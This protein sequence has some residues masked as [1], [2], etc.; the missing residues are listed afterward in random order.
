MK[1]LLLLATVV[2]FSFVSNAQS[3][4]KISFDIKNYNDT[5]SYLTFYQFDK[6]FIKDTCATIKNGK[7]VFKGKN[8]L[9]KGVYSLVNQNK[10]LMFD[11]I[12]D[13][14][15]QT[16]EINS[17]MGENLLNNL[18]SNSPNEN[19]FFDYIRYISQM[20]IKFMEDREKFP[21]KTKKDTL[22]LIEKQKEV[23]QLIRDYEYKFLQNNKGTYMADVVNIKTEK[24][25]SDPKNKIDDLTKYQYHKNH[26]WDDVNLQDD[27][28]LRNPFFH[29]KLNAYFDNIVEIN[30]D[31]TIVEV[32]K[33]MKKAKEGS[34]LYKL[35]LSH[36][37][38]KYES[39]TYMGFDK[40]FVHISDNYFKKGKAIGIY[41]DE[42][43]VQKIIKRADKLKPLLIGA[44]AP[45]LQMIRAED[46]EKMKSMGFESAS[47]SDEL[48]KVYY[49]NIKEVEPMYVKLS[50]VQA[51]YT[52][53]LFW[54]VDCGHC[55]KEVPIIKEVY[56][57][58]IKEKIDLKVYGV[59]T[60][61]EGEKYLKYIKEN[62]LPFINLYDGSYINN[63]AEKYDVVSTPVLFLLDKNK[64]I[65]AKK[66]SADQIK[67]FIDF[68]EKEKNKKS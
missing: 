49:D 9:D 43:V 48:T 4:Y 22:A 31:S 18:T 54:D 14:Y 33:I 41:Q 35:M 47:S 24:L 25:L 32:D 38:H 61:H 68:L 2:L 7:I 10:N 23:D 34:L 45:D 60:L 19:K 11:F 12:I 57:E 20:N 30:P 50:D 39:S 66:I 27:G 65:K 63:V 64:I 56:E 42:E 51:D 59:Y 16:L 1:K 44:K 28:T 53:L 55:K 6:T 58:L 52:L 40:V 15:T 3:G 67:Y 36:L 37:T 26:F 62:K 29:K 5:I 46:F 13:D 17:E 21:L 8:K